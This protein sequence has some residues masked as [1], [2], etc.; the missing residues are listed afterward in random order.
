[1]AHRTAWQGRSRRQGYSKHFEG[2][3]WWL[4]GRARE[5]SADQLRRQG[6]ESTNQDANEY[7]AGMQLNAHEDTRSRSSIVFCRSCTV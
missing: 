3:L 7:D 2:D 5:K 6:Q 1:M 4:I